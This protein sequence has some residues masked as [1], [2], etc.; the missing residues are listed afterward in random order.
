[1]SVNKGMDTMY[2]H[3]ASQDGDAALRMHLRGRS[4]RVTQAVLRERPLRR[5]GMRT[6]A[7]T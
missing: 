2:E 3:P 4:V 6:C 1:M 7:G 5:K